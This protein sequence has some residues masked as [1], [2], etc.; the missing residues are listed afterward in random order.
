ML[1]QVT[2]FGR[3]G[4]KLF[5]RLVEAIVLPPPPIVIHDLIIQCPV[6]TRLQGKLPPARF[7]CRRT[8][9]GPGKPG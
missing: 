7:V 9:R 8:A 5:S 6:P 3:S 1:Y 2:G 4:R